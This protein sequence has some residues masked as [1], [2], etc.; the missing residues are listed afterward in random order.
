MVRFSISFVVT[1]PV[2]VTCEGVAAIELRS[3]PPTPSSIK[4]FINPS[5]IS[6]PS[7]KPA[8]SYVPVS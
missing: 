6:D 5:V 1:T 7:S 3:S 2:K 4:S 8:I